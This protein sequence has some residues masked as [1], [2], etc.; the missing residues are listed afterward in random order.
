MSEIKQP[1]PVFMLVY[2]QGGVG[3]ST[4]AATAKKSVM[5]DLEGGTKFFEERGIKAQVKQARTWSVYIRLLEALIAHPGV[6][7]IVIDP[8]GE[9]VDMA[10]KGLPS[11]FKDVKTGEPTLQGWG[12]LKTILKD[13]FRYLRDCGKNVILI[14]HIEFTEDEGRQKVLPKMEAKMTWTVINSMDIVAYMQVKR[15]DE[16]A[17]VRVLF[18]DESYDKIYTKDRTGRLEEENVPDFPAIYAKINGMDV[19]AKTAQNA[20]QGDESSSV[21][22]ESETSETTEKQAVEKPAKASTKPAVKTQEEQDRENPLMTE[23]DLVK[24]YPKSGAD[25]EA[26]DGSEADPVVEG[27]PASEKPSTT[28]LTAKEKARANLKRSIEGGSK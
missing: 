10:K 25:L 6:E 15:N 23:E 18:I 9:L 4:F 8:I 12:V 24:A 1:K 11:S 26:G 7:T 20:P 28:P 14:G 21:A 13:H 22:S 5:I 3:K 17:K 2:G 19:P 16:G 27:L